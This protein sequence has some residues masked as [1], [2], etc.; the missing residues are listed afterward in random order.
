MKG[1]IEAYYPNIKEKVVRNAIAYFREQGINI[2]S[3]EENIILKAKVQL[4]TSMGKSCVKK[5]GDFDNSM[6]SKDGYEIC[7]FI[8]LYLLAKIKEET[9]LENW[10]S[11]RFL[12]KIK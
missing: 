4:A 5:D 9:I 8:G 12:N 11:P 3:M 1:H 7:E 2:T 6:G 10:E